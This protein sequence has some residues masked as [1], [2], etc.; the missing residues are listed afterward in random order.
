MPHH[1][2]LDGSVNVLLI[3]LDV[4]EGYARRVDSGKHDRTGAQEAMSV[5]SI[6]VVHKGLVA[7][8]KFHELFHSHRSHLSV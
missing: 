1:R 4:W 7:T 6:D 3:G 8:N 2:R 5:R